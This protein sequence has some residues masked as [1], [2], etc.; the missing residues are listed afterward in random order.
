MYRGDNMQCSTLDTEVTLFWRKN[1]IAINNAGRVFA[2]AIMTKW[3]EQRQQF[4]SL[5]IRKRRNYL[6]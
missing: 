1:A 2:A 4:C 6:K 5:S 3:Q